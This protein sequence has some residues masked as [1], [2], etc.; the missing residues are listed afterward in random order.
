MSRKLKSS[1]N[2]VPRRRCLPR[3][4]QTQRGQ[5]ITQILNAFFTRGYDKRVRPNYGAVIC[6]VVDIAHFRSRPL[7][8]CSHEACSAAW[9]NFS[10]SGQR[11]GGGCSFSLQCAPVIDLRAGFLGR[12]HGIGD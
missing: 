8:R 1:G 9:A 3:P 10:G 7:A 2:Y 4:R 11:D 5:N 12:P 6:G